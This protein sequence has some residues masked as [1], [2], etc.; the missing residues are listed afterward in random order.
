MQTAEIYFQIPL[1][2]L[3]SLNQN[4]DEFVRQSRLYTAIELFKAHKLSSG[5][6]AKLAGM[7]QFEFWMELGK[8]K[9]PLIDYEPAELEAE[10]EAFKE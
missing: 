8:L 3:S 2:I 5:Q 9:I 7:G 10:L 1:N 4:K 6:A